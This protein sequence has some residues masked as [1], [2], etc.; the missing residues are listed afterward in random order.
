MHRA[1]NGSKDTRCTTRR[2]MDYEVRGSA[3]WVGR[4]ALWAS[5]VGL[6]LLAELADEDPQDV[7]IAGVAGTPHP[8]EQPVV[9]EQLPRVLA[10][11]GQ[12][13]PLGLGQAHLDA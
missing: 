5:G 6:E 2:T 11:L 9:R 3:S 4:D 10:E 1:M 7:D 13:R 12:Q 8:F